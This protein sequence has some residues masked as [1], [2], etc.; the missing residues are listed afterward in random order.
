MRVF[1][2]HVCG[3]VGHHI[4]FRAVLQEFRAPPLHE[5]SGRVRT[6]HST[7]TNTAAILRSY[8]RAWFSGAGPSGTSF[9]LALCSVSPADT[10]ALSGLFEGDHVRGHIQLSVTGIVHGHL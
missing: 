3:G 7:L 8:R 4:S 2:I 9:A 6:S 5:S 10:A 1:S